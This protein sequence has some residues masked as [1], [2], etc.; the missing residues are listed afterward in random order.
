MRKIVIL[1]LILISGILA[2]NY[3]DSSLHGQWHYDSFTDGKFRTV[4]GTLLISDST[5]T[6]DGEIHED[7]PT[8]PQKST[9]PC[10]LIDGEC[11]YDFEKYSTMPLSRYY[12]ILDSVIYFSWDPIST[13]VR[14]FNSH[15]GRECA[16][17]SYSARFATK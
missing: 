4:S 14:S 3:T 2:N 1:I 15:L 8:S 12:L 16:N 5:V 7:H 11:N 9:I 17:Y 6:F 10:T 13:P